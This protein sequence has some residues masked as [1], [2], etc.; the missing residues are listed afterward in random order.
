MNF[1]AELVDLGLHQFDL[2]AR[3]FGVLSLQL[4]VLP[5]LVPLLFLDPELQ[6]SVALLTLDQ[7][8]L[9]RRVLRELFKLF[10]QLDELP[11]ALTLCLCF[12][13]HVLYLL[14]ERPK[15]AVD[16]R[17]WAAVVSD[18]LLC[19]LVVA[20][21][22]EVSIKCGLHSLL[23]PLLQ[24]SDEILIRMLCTFHEGV[25]KCVSSEDL[26]RAAGLVDLEVADVV[27]VLTVGVGG[28]LHDPGVSHL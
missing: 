8:L 7:L 28:T 1:G 10:L 2:F 21:G 14:L 27:R 25:D 23:E 3:F 24:I 15:T 20:Q 13:V 6:L 9:D 19:D 5:G 4:Q 12:D 18:R 22:R 26:V 17:E 16:V 11:F